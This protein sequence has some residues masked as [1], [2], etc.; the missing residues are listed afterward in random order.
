MMAATLALGIDASR[1]TAPDPAALEGLFEV[2]PAEWASY[3]AGLALVR[4]LVG[5][6]DR[7]R[8]LLMLHA[9]NG[10]NRLGEDGEQLTTLLMFGRVATGLEEA[11]ACEALY[12]LLLPHADL[13]AVD[14]IAGCCWGPIE[15][16]LGRLAL[17]LGRRA[18]A[19]EHLGRARASADRVGA[20]LI[21]AEAASLE[22]QCGRPDVT[23][24]EA[25]DSRRIVRQICFGEMGSSGPCRIGAGPFA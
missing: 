4:W 24:N 17:A 22:Q 16:E 11:A 21:A 15:L 25:G 20:P 18:D 13:W 2:D 9:D 5:D 6:R 8:H 7:A 19:V 12:E 10:F 3:A 1:G 23:Q 14:G